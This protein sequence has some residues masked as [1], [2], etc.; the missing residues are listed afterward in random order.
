MT[1]RS[2]FGP[3][4][5]RPARLNERVSVIDATVATS[6]APPVAVRTLGVAVTSRT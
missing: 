2:D 5:L 1:I 6:K 4:L 3:Y